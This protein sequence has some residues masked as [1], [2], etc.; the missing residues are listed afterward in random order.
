MWGWV[1]NVIFA[2]WRIRGSARRTM[3]ERQSLVRSRVA[4][5]QGR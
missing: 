5:E 1:I 2:E 3:L 4:G